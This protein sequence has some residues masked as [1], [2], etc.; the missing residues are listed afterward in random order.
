MIPLDLKANDLLKILDN[1]SD[2]IFVTDRNGKI[3]YVN[4]VCESHY[5]L[6]VNDLLGKSA[7]DIVEAGY[8]YPSV[9]PEVLEKKI[10]V[11]I[12][13]ETILG[14]KLIVTATP[15]FDINGEIEFIIQNARN[16]TQ[17][18]AIK[19]DLENAR[20]IVKRYKEEVQKL[21]KKQQKALN[22]IT[23]SKEM[24]RLLG[25]AKHVATTDTTVLITGES[26]TGKGVVTKYIHQVSNRRDDAFITINCAAIP[27]SL[28]E[29]ELFGYEAGA[30]TGANRQGKIGLIELAHQGT[31]FL[32]EIGDLPLHLQSK[33]LQVIQERKFIR[34]GGQDFVDVDV[35]IIA[36]TNQKLAQMITQGTFREDL[37]YRLSVVEMEIP[38][39]RNRRDDIIPLIYLFLNR[40][41]QQYD[42]HH[43]ISQDTLDHLVDYA[44]PGNVRELEH[45]MERLAVTVRDT[46]IMP[47]HLPSAIRQ[48]E[49]LFSS[50]LGHQLVSLNDAV[51]EL[52][53]QMVTRAHSQFGSSYKVAKRLRISQSKANRL[54]RRFVKS[55]KTE[56]H[57]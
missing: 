4:P 7:Y 37:Y 39:L 16:I 50:K 26:G 17:L 10:R 51:E 24:K 19:Q 14:K 6:K 54:I 46:T 52:T 41:D 12:E 56:K 28:M 29:S 13:Q 25:L 53:R 9:M 31:L 3:I 48:P 5:G 20:E 33:L 36:A 30:F 38:T 45:L 43:I 34:V 22:L 32:D 8:C 21:R 11:N 49:A 23:H 44:W 42:R 40:F 35:R 57:M 1:S 15:V 18:A 27:E 55:P 47:E 2:E